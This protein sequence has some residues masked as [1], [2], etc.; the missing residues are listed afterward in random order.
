MLPCYEC[1]YHPKHIYISWER[2]MGRCSLYIISN[3]VVLCKWCLLLNC[4]NFYIPIGVSPLSVCYLTRKWMN[5]FAVLIYCFF[6]E[7]VSVFIIV[8]FLCSCTSY[9][10]DKFW[11]VSNMD[12]CKLLTFYPFIYL[13][14]LIILLVP[15]G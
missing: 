3:I 4:R 13:W 1:E 9:F 6:S 7:F 5:V 10:T 14:T 15:F 11:I 2:Q 12:E 8:G